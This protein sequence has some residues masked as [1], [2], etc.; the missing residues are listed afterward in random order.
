MPWT[1]PVIMGAA[2]ATGLLVSRKTQR[3]LPLEDSQRIG[4]DARRSTPSHRKAC[5]GIR[6]LRLRSLAQPAIMFEEYRV[7]ESARR[8]TALKPAW[9]RGVRNE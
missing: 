7:Q 2:I 6:R 4:I 5:Q 3:A 1:Y 8:G 9:Q